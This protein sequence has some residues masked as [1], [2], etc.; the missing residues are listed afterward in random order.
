MML[1]PQLYM[2]IC[3]EK[4]TGLRMKINTHSDLSQNPNRFITEPVS[5]GPHLAYHVFTVPLVSVKQFL[6]HPMMIQEI[7]HKYIKP[8]QTMP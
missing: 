4:Q 5:T 2:C 6:H 7:F 8:L 1:L 3:L